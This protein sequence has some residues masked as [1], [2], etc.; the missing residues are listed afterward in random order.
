MGGSVFGFHHASFET[1]SASAP[2][3]EAHLSVPSTVILILRSAVRRVSK[4]ARQLCQRAL[5]I[6]ALCLS[7]T[8]ASALD[9]DGKLVQGGLVLG[10]A[11]PGASVTLDGRAVPVTPDG[12]FVFGFG[13]DATEA[14]LA[15][16]LPD[17]TREERRL[18]IEKRQFDIQRV[19]GVPQN[20]VTP[21]PI[22]LAR[23]KREAMEIRALR[24]V[25]GT[26]HDFVTPMI[27]P[28]HGPISGVYGSQ[29]ILNGEPRAPHMGVDIAAPAGSPIVAAAGG[30]VRF[31][32][33]LFLTGNTILID[34]G[35][36]LET[37]YAHLSRIDVTPGQRLR[38]GEQ[39]GLVGATGRVTGP[40]LHWGMEWFEIRLDPQLV[41]RPMPAS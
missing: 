37:S 38:Q 35:Y 26:G 39:I 18:A 33:E 6:L 29:R 34:H 5:L 31:A 11:V 1:R 7:G 10:T 21:D 25:A 19:D 30:V 17:G 9:L 41:V 23:I 36:G 16:T 40:H 4:D 2:Q 15:V 20:T 13:R 32:G 28:A 3:D 12:R 14:V 8:T 27:W 24:D 22:E